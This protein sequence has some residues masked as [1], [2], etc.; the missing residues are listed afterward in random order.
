MSA[1]KRAVD[2]EEPGRVAA[3][4]DVDGTLLRVQSGTLYIGYLRRRGLMARRDIVR[5]YWGYITYR[6]GILNMRKLA[7]VTSRWLRGREEDE[8][9]EH[10]KD[11]YQ[12]EV[13]RYF[14]PELLRKVDEHR[15][16]GHDVVLLTGGT[17]YLNDLIAAELEIEYVVASQLEV[18]DGRFTGHAIPPLCY[19][20]GKLFHAE[21]FAEKRG[22]A[23][24][25][26]YFYTDS[27][28]DL[29][30]LERV[31]FPI[32]VYPDP[33]LRIEAKKRGWPT[34]DGKAGALS[35]V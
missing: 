32:A 2:V 17:R 26:S 24:E 23:L 30:F 22:I 21:R 27:I 12:A 11:W 4:F 16:A 14:R 6:L 9:R 25:R 34:I 5:I 28:T 7:S 13:R 33:R 10:C 35:P 18:V 29:P 20:E 19:G 3:F 31:G 1:S 8:V 15:S